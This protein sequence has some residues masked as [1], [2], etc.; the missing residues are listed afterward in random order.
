[1]LRNTDEIQTITYQAHKGFAIKTKLIHGLTAMV[2]QATGWDPTPAPS[3]PPS[4]T[5]P[6]SPSSNG[7]LD[8]FKR[9]PPPS[10]SP[11]TLCT[12]RRC[13]SLSSRWSTRCGHSKTRQNSSAGSAIGSSA[14]RSRFP[15]SSSPSASVSTVCTPGNRGL[16]NDACA[17]GLIC[18]HCCLLALVSRLSAESSSAVTTSSLPL[19]RNCSRGLPR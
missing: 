12:C 14:S 11:T 6:P 19:I 2:V 8:R 13:P 18:V 7:K 9:T 5:A 4:P 17:A 1:M 15:P 3:P 10:L 16:A